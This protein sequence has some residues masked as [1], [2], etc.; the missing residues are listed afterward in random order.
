VLLNATSD[1][2]R[3]ESEEEK[4]NTRQRIYAE[5]NPHAYEK[6]TRTE[7]NDQKKKDYKVP[8]CGW[9]RI[10][11]QTR[12]M[13]RNTICFYLPS[14]FPFP[15]RIDSRPS[16]V[17]SVEPI[18]QSIHPSIRVENNNTKETKARFINPFPDSQRRPT[19]NTPDIMVP[20]LTPALLDP[21][22]HLVLTRQLCPLSESRLADPRLR[23]GHCLCRP[24]PSRLP[25]ACVIPRPKPPLSASRPSIVDLCRRWLIVIVSN[26]A[27]ILHV[28]SA[29]WGI[30]HISISGVF[31]RPH[32]WRLHKPPLSSVSY[33]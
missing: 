19:S 14:A 20:S 11:R 26:G 29:V 12:E 15:W 33:M 3:G 27:P 1:G 32:R 18:D 9:N 30:P 10:A 8:S 22:L 4:Q 28:P 21:L 6:G 5:P 7:T 24:N 23:H 13:N 31:R 16:S 25:R 17:V 2:K